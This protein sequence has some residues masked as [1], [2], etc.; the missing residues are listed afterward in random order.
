[1]PVANDSTILDAIENRIKTLTWVKK[2]ESEN[3][4]LEFSEVHD[5]EI[6]YIQIYDNGQSPWRLPS[7]AVQHRP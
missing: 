6:P 7:R 4:K 5:H 2:V 1:M 3:I